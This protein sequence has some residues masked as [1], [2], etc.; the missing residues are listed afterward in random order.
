MLSSLFPKVCSSV[1][2]VEEQ[3]R[4]QETSLPCS[5]LSE[6]TGSSSNTPEETDDVDNSSLDASYSMR[7]APWAGAT[8]SP[9]LTADEEGMLL[10]GGAVEADSSAEACALPEPP[11][12]G[13][14]GV[15]ALIHGHLCRLTQPIIYSFSPSFMH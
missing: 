15:S 9:P 12:D 3:L 14:R 1:A 13:K 5:G 7:A 2:A 11:Q 6:G 4:G 8:S 10:A